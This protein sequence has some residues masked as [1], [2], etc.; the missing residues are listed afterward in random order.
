MPIDATL[1]QVEKDIAAGDLGLARDRLHGLIASYP[2]RLEFRPLLGDI[3]WQLQFPA[4]AGR[5]WYLVD[6]ALPHRQA[7]RAR[8]ERSCGQDPRQILLALKFRGQLEDLA[9]PFAKQRLVAL[10]SRMEEKF[11]YTLDF[12][13]RGRQRYLP[14]PRQARNNRWLSIGCAVGLLLAVSLMIFGLASL[15]NQLF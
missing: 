2:N 9:D 5:Y 14:S 13:R 12:A 6:D 11:G 1:Q 4:M 8:F 3:Y 15:V 10:Q 7:A